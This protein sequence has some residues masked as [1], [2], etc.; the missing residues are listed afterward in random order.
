MSPP[1]SVPIRASFI[2]PL[3]F[4]MSGY[5][6]PLPH[7]CAIAYLFPDRSTLPHSKENPACPAPP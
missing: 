6:P 3:S 2:A 5:G 1:K 4:A 7:A